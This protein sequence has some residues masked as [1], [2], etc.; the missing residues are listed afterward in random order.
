MTQST[1]V[2]SSFVQ[3]CM[4]MTQ[5]SKDESISPNRQWHKWIGHLS[6]PSDSPS[7]AGLPWGSYSFLNISQTH[8]LS[9]CVA[10]ISLSVSDSPS[11]VSSR[12]AVT[13]LSPV[14][15]TKEVLRKCLLSKNESLENVKA[16]CGE[17]NKGSNKCEGTM[18][19]K[20]IKEWEISSKWGA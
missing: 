19:H 11:T 16:Q 4:F 7:S 3:V 13:S 20:W 6:S 12:M 9:Y 17:E 5:K 1:S 14:P 2:Q 10:I 18:E 8:F 15:D